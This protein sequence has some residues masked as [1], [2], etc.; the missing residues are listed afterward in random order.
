E[1][2]LTLPKRKRARRRALCG[3]R[4]GSSEIA[5]DELDELAPG[6]G[7]EGAIRDLAVLEE[8][9]GGD[10]SDL[11]AHGDL[12]RLVDV[13]LG[14]LDLSG[15]CGREIVDDRSHG[16]AGTAPGRPEVDEDRDLTLR[17]EEHTS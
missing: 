15:I 6:Q 5:V 10:R 17:S 8:D 4:G 3:F 13:H 11:V 7:P 16:A 9:E 12:R 2:N 1:A 14:D